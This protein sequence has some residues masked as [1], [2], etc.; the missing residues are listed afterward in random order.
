[1]DKRSGVSAYGKT[2]PELA[3][4]FAVHLVKDQESFQG[5]ER[6][7]DVD[8]FRFGS[9]EL[10]KAARDND[11][12]L[13]ANSFFIRVMMPSI[14]PT[15]PKMTPLRMAWI[16]SWQMAIFGL[17]SSMRGSLAAF[18]K[19]LPLKCQCPEQWHHPDI[20]HQDGGHRT[21]LPYQSQ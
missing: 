16:V 10:A 8:K 15:K 9:H 4:L 5:Q 1:M 19:G 17:I 7:D 20:P 3:L 2:P 14:W 11:K 6:F 12:G 13:P 18:G 21:S